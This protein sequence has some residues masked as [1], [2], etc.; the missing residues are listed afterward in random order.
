MGGGAEPEYQ[1]A[2]TPHDLHTIVYR[3]DYVASA[4]HEVAHWCLAGPRRRQLLDYGYWY[5]PDGRTAD[6]QAEFERVEIKPQAL[7]WVF[8]DALGIPFELSAD[9]IAA[10][11][12]PSPTFAKAVAQQR[13][14]YAANGLPPRAAQFAACLQRARS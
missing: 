8:A 1:P 13:R 10:G 12:A 4:L 9:N 2:A 5:A 3:H 7:E 11:G 14:D 6:Q